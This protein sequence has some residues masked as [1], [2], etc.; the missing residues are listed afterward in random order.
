MFKEG[1][2]S[3]R[4][5][6]LLTSNLML[7]GSVNYSTWKIVLKSYLEHEELRDYVDPSEH[8][9]DRKKDKNAKLKII[10]L[11]EPIT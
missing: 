5:R 1:N 7:M 4:W 11:A 3:W 8:A 2:R 10:F 6:Q 9:V